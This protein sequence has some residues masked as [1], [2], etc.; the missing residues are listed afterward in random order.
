MGKVLLFIGTII[1]LLGFIYTL[2]P[3]LSFPPRLPGD[4]YIRRGNFTLYFPIVT[5]ILISIALSLLAYFFF[6]K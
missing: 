5:S 6:R 3:R 1:L 2:F 4:V